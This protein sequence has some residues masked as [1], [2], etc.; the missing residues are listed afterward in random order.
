MTLQTPPSPH[1]HSGLRIS[2]MML[3]VMAALIPAIICYTWFFGW[4]LV[5][6]GIIAVITAVASEALMLKL[7]QR[8]LRPFLG[9]GSAALTG[10]LLAFC[11]PPL[12]PWW[13]TVLGVAFALIVGKHLYGGLGYNPFNPAMVG[14]V[15]LLISFPLEMTSWMPPYI[16]EQL[17]IGFVDTLRMIF[18]NHFPYGLSID[19]LSS[20]TPLDAMKTDLGLNNT[21]SEIM[22]SNA[23][24]GDFAG[25][26][27]EWVGNWL[28]LGG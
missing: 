28:L 12:A 4:G 6:N 7:R 21:V 15:M 24:F 18:L 17:E 16:L 22:E 26:G 14:Y 11:I 3:R 27:W 2:G 9:D 20:A 25:T 10:M 1:I 23:L 13:I 19:A 8:P 5:I